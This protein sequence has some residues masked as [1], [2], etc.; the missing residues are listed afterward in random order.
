[1][2]EIIDTTQSVEAHLKAVYDKIEEKGGTVPENKN[3]ENLPA[4]IASIGG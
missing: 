3:F 1:M 2:E 4:A